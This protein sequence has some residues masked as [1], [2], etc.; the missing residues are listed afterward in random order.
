MSSYLPIPDHMQNEAFL[1]SQGPIGFN[2][3]NYHKELQ[4]D[5]LNFLHRTL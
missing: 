1:L 5:I 2:R 4:S 3:E